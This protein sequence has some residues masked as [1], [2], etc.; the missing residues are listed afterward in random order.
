MIKKSEKSTIKLLMIGPFPPPVH[1]S[2][3][4]FASI[5]SELQDKCNVSSVNI[6]PGTLIRGMRYH[7]AKL[8]KVVVASFVLFVSN[9]DRVY[10]TID[11]GFGMIYTFVFSLIIKLRRKD[12]VL[13][14]RSFAYINKRN[15]LMLALSGIAKKATHIFLCDEMKSKFERQYSR[16]GDSMV[17]SNAKHIYVDDFP[18]SKIDGCLRFGFISNLSSSKGFDEAV[19]VVKEIV[20]RYGNGFVFNVAG[21]PESKDVEGR[22]N[23][24]RR[25]L[26]AIF[27]YKGLVLGEEK[28]KFYREIDILLF[29]TRYINE[30]QPNVVLEALSHGVPVLATNRGC[31]KGDVDF[32]CGAIFEEE[33]Y[34][35][36][37]LSWIS[38]VL[39]GKFDLDEYKI[40]ALKKARLLK[41]A[42]EKNHG[43]LIKRLS[44]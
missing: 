40:S 13:H 39:D 25:E 1:G 10:L 16:C 30:A 35:D 28:N 7:F 44:R 33:A 21:M 14:H 8:V 2:S 23:L 31:I 5:R 29:P 26:G 22:I 19:A 41:D 11:A 36:L 6:S 42:S 34:H 17:V 3:K 4:N 37:S 38:D 43:E 15:Y 12:F 20:K 24:Y 27:N 32:S 9:Y 18:S